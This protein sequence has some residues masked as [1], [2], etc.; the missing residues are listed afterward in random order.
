VVR[1][2]IVGAHYGWMDFL[3]QRITAVVMAVYTLLVLAIALYSG[4]IDYAL[5][6]GLFSHTAFRIATLLFALAL[7]WHAWIGMRDIWMD[8]I[9]PTALRLTLEV[10][11]IIVLV[12]YVGWV[13]LILWG[14][15]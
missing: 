5:W 2:A 14:R 7:L 15:A 8:Y 3:A 6:R 13:L 10:L 9:K 11:T 1:R 12:A 4:G